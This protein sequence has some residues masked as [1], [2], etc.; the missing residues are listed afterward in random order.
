MGC[1]VKLP[2]HSHPVIITAGRP[3]V[4]KKKDIDGLHHLSNRC[5]TMDRSRLSLR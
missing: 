1:P 4:A 2:Y 3:I 5:M